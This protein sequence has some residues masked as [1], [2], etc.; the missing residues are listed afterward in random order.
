MNVDTTPEEIRK[1]ASQH[2]DHVTVFVETL[3]A[4]TQLPGGA[5]GFRGLVSM[6]PPHTPF[7]SMHRCSDSFWASTLKEWVAKTKKGMTG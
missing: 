1:A 6:V 4:V 7:P 2:A 3:V 5:L